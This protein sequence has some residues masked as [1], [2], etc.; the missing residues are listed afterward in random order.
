MEM[1]HQDE[2]EVS[3]SSLLEEELDEKLVPKAT[4]DVLAK[5][6]IAEEVKFIRDLGLIIKVFRKRFIDAPSLF[7]EDVSWSSIC[8]VMRLKE[9]IIFTRDV[10]VNVAAL[11]LFPFVLFILKY[12][13]LCFMLSLVIGY[14]VCY[15]CA[16]GA[17][18]NLKD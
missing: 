17:Y 14:H 2:E 3:V 7:S 16:A 9:D 15:L 10:T 18:F 4:F 13:S 6:L 12:K 1:F 8:F 5:D 11:I